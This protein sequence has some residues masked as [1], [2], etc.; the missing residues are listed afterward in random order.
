MF[1]ENVEFKL[2]AATKWLASGSAPREHCGGVG[3]TQAVMKNRCARGAFTL[4]ELLVV[5]AIIAILAA[6]IFP[7]LSR[8]KMKGQSIACMN[9]LRQLSLGCKMYADENR[10]SLA[11]S[12]PLG[13]STHPVNPY[14]W[15][16][17]WASTLPQ[18][19]TYGPAPQFS[20][21]N[22]YALEQGVIWPYVKSAAVYRCPADKRY[23]GGMPVVR[24]YSMN[25]W[26]NGRSYG[27]PT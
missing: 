7:A 9:N 20:A 11:S 26:M 24:S 2:P 1:K 22:E 16:P 12:W 18:N 4:L 25:S 21:T 15:C 14:S 17:G 3:E 10:G 23:V 6:L 19:L 13:D 8:A 5:I 27:D